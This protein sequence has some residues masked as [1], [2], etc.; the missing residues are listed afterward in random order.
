MLLVD[1]RLDR[2]VVAVNVRRF[3]TLACGS[4]SG[5]ESLRARAIIA[6]HGG[7]EACPFWQPIVSSAAQEARIPRGLPAERGRLRRR[8]TGIGAPVAM[9]IRGDHGRPL[10]KHPSTLP[11]MRRWH[12]AAAAD[13]WP[14]PPADPWVSGPNNTARFTV[15]TSHKNRATTMSRQHD[16]ELKALKFAC[17]VGLVPAHFARADP[18]DTVHSH[19]TNYQSDQA[20]LATRP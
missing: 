5:R 4:F 1:Q 7:V 10:C 12:A 11:A 9:Q 3:C 19:H 14:R 18:G 6:V 20:Y 8:D 13:R 16:N 15:H 17:L 2:R